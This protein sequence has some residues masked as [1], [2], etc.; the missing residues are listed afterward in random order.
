[1]RGPDG[2]VLVDRVAAFLVI[3]KSDQQTFWTIREKPQV[4]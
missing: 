3:M 1:M 2:R 4:L